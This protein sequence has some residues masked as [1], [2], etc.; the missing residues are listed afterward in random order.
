MTQY[1]VQNNTEL[2]NAIERLRLALEAIEAAEKKPS[3]AEVLEVLL[4]RDEVKTAL[5]NIS[6]PDTKEVDTVIQLDERLQ[7][8]AKVL[9]RQ[10]NISDWRASVNPDESSWW[11]FFQKVKKINSWDRLDWMWNL[12]TAGSLAVTASLF[13]TM[14]QALAVGGGFTWQQS[15]AGIAQGTGLLVIAQGSLTAKGQERVKAM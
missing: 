1:Q 9:A 14:G 7:K 11:W 10:G 3:Q 2:Q 5:E 6:N 12:L 15:F 8:Q 13:V 4:A